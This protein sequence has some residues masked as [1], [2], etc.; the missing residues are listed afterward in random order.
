MDAILEWLTQPMT[1][2]TWAVYATTILVMG[3]LGYA[4]GHLRH[5]P[6]RIKIAANLLFERVAQ[7][8]KQIVATA[9]ACADNTARLAGI[10]EYLQDKQLAAAMFGKRPGEPDRPIHLGKGEAKR[11]G[12][13][14]FQNG[15]FPVIVL[16]KDEDV[17]S[18]PGRR[19]ERVESE[20]LRHN[21]LFTQVLEGCCNHS[22]RLCAIEKRLERIDKP[23]ALAEES[24]GWNPAAGLAAW[25]KAMEENAYPPITD[26][27]GVP[28]A[29][30]RP[31]GT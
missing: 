11:I 31:K 22:Q 30:L 28:P 9:T 15:E 8:E 14:E 7:L 16:P 12:N 13:V 5:R 26:P 3:A 20:I 17:M 19:L 6:Q 1:A 18:L 29:T 23:S 4:L 27:K 21:N 24:P 10:E 25:N 2:P